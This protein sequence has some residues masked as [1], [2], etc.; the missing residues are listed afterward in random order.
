[1]IH[2]QPLPL[3]IAVTFAQSP[4]VSSGLRD[5]MALAKRYA[6]VVQIVSRDRP[7][8]VGPP[9]KPMDV[10]AL[11]DQPTVSLR[12]PWGHD[13]VKIAPSANDLTAAL[14]D[15]QLDFPGNPLQP[16]CGYEEWAR[17][18]SQGTV[19]TVYAHVATDP[20]HPGKIALQYW[21]FYAFNDWNNTHEGDWEMIQLDFDAPT[22]R[23]ALAQRPTQ[24]GYSQHEGAERAKWGD[25]KLH[26]VDG[27]HPVVHPAKGSHA[28]FFDEALYL[29]ASGSEGVGCDDTRGPTTEIRP[30]VQTI[31]SD[32][33]A[34]HLVFPWIQFTGRWGELQRAFFNG[35]TGPNLKLQ[36]LEP[37][38]WSQNYW[39]D[40]SIAVPGGGAFGTGA[41]DF[42]CTAVAKGSNGLRAT[43]DQPA[44]AF[45][46]L[47]LL[48]ALAAFA[49][50]RTTWRPVA[51]LRL[52]RRRAW[53]QIF[54]GAARMYAEQPSVFVGIGVLAL[55]VSIAVTLLQ[56]G[57]LRA[58]KL[59]GVEA[60][61]ERGG[62]LVLIVVALATAVTLL[63]LG[64]V[65]AATARALVEID[66]GRPISAPRAYT[67]SLDSIAP[68]FGA[69]VIASVVVSVFMTTLVLVPAAIWLAI[70]WSLIV[71]AIELENCSAIEAL[72]RSARLVR[73]GW[74]KIGSLAVA[75]A[76]LAVLIGPLLSAVL[77]FAT[78]APLAWVNL[79]SGI[80][81][82]STMP[83]VALVT[84][85]VYFDMRV[86][87][88]LAT[89][90][91]SDRLPAEVEL[92]VP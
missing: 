36:W 65:M 88:H 19:P 68:L 55:P 75:G 63:G 41:T 57:L 20:G 24:V 52:A 40:R 22:A 23:D 5:E 87:E 11:F 50:S 28:N 4:T 56:V 9:F 83:F 3:L 73:N 37:I 16:G 92:L 66:A 62:L 10:N 60:G 71:P 81:Y 90:T 25:E 84:V 47:I 76:A 18:V 78:R 48:I 7:C 67:L 54:A 79:V 70:R 82:A 12:G 49:F 31:P 8:G 72:R 43:L 6:P 74:L 38:T 39:R 32:P 21:L 80:V 59:F 13:L 61:G 35:P 15:Y 14:Y 33:V 85:Y 69:L 34:A 29:G 91:E 17:R 27:T 26:W 89:Q 2:R 64:F 58:S 30:A 45:V 77:I 53:G 42:F 86:R 1:M 46:V 51:P 44:P